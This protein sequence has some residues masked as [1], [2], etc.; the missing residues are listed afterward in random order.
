MI[1]VLALAAILGWA[2]PSPTPTPTED[3]EEYKAYWKSFKVHIE[4][5][6]DEK[7]FEEFKQ[8]FLRGI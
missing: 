7:P 1:L 2:N 8:S 5:P 3:F 6:V 4:A